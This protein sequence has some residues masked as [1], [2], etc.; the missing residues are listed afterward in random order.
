MTTPSSVIL[1]DIES[2]SII[3]ELSASNVRYVVWSQNMSMVA[4][5]SKHCKLFNK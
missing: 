4:L 3:A 5:L 1:F 2:R